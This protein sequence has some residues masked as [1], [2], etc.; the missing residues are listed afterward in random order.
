MSLQL[1]EIQ[2]S[3]AVKGILNY[4]NIDI[5]FRHVSRT[6][7][8][9]QY[10]SINLQRVTEFDAKAAYALV[11]LFIQSVHINNSFTIDICQNETVLKVMKETE[12][13]EILNR[14]RRLK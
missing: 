7:R 8:P 10:L 9:N 5:F 2:S 14:A 6:F 4:K 1:T 13:F 11:K 12:T 3:I